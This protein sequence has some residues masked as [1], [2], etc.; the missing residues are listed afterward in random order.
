MLPSF[1]YHTTR[2]HIPEDATLLLVALFNR[3]G[4]VTNASLVL[5]VLCTFPEARNGVIGATATT[6]SSAWKLEISILET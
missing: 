5:F 1:F 2:R 3:D 4:A 6:T